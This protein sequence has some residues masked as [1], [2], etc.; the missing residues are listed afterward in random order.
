[1]RSLRDEMIVALRV[2]AKLKELLAADRAALVGAPSLVQKA[3][4][5]N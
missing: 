1:V 5:L 2:I 3:R 4:G